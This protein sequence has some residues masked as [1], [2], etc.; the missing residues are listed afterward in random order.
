M[1]DRGRKRGHKVGLKEGMSQIRRRYQDDIG[2]AEGNIY[3]NGE[4]LKLLRLS[5]VRE[6]TA[7]QLA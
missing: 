4:F 7:A 3:F 5:D 6:A 2:A 1:N